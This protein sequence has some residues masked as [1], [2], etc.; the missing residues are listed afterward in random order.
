MVD[1]ANKRRGPLP[2]Q[3]KA[4]PYYPERVL[5]IIDLHK[6]GK[7]LTEVAN[8]IGI[9]PAGVSHIVNRWG[10]WAEENAQ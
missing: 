9:T 3:T 8:I 2:G 1:I 10:K 6:K 5:R 4:T 7:S